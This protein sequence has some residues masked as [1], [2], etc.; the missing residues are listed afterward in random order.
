MADNLD[1]FWE[2]LKDGKDC[3]TEIS[4]ER[5]EPKHSYSDSKWGGFINDVDKFD[6]LFFNIQMLTM[7]KE[8]RS[9]DAHV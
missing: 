5:W 2:N 7:R 4:E 9:L 1:E 3:I 8:R 6:P